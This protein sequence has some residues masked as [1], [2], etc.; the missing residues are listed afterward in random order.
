MLSGIVPAN[1]QKVLGKI[2]PAQEFFR[3]PLDAKN[4]LLPGLKLLDMHAWVLCR[5]E[6]PLEHA[7]MVEKTDVASSA[8]IPELAVLDFNISGVE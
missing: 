2:Q 5:N 3:Q 1:C 4:P 7:L 6:T 8:R